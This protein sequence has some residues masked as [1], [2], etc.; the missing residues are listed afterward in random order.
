MVHAVETRDRAEGHMGTSTPSMNV[1]LI[2]PNINV[3]KDNYYS[4]G[5]ASI[6]AVLKQH[7][8]GIQAYN[9]F[10]FGEEEKARLFRFV[11][12][13]RPK[14]IGLTCVTS[15]YRFVKDI[16]E[17]LKS[18]FPDIVLAVGGVHPTLFP[19]LLYDSRSIDY[20]F[21]GEA[22]DTFLDFCRR[23]HDNQD[24]TDISGVAYI[25][26]DN[27]LVINEIGALC[28]DLNKFPEPERELFDYG[29]V[30]KATGGAAT[31]LF[32][33]GCPNACTFCSNQALAEV[34]RLNRMTSRVRDVDL[35]IKEIM[36]VTK[37]YDVQLIRIIDEIMGV[38]RQ[39]LLDF[40][41]EYKKHVRIPFHCFQRVNIINEESI[42]ALKE[43]GCIQVNFGIESG[44]T[45]IRNYLMRKNISDEQ[46]IKAFGT[47]YKLKMNTAASNIIGLPFETIPM[48]YDTINL[49]RK[50]LPTVNAVN[51]FYPYPQTKLYNLCKAF[52]LIDERKALSKDYVERKKAS[53]LK[54]PV[55]DEM[56]DWFV[57]N[58]NRLIYKDLFTVIRNPR[59]RFVDKVNGERRDYEGKPRKKVEE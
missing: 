56:L 33:R 58:W 48:I 54:L 30:L 57:N 31:F 17:Y 18:Q 3:A 23:V 22:E 49:N 32:N 10:A 26:G 50:I 59:K 19:D 44:N 11:S 1:L 6:A 42:I 5:L 34:Y 25:G 35:A 38:K 41:K 47:C 29:S 43:A 55:K 15:Q 2:Y 24:V 14:V 27:K 8:F 53:I 45:M 52:D 51:I 46:I 28:G 37:K 7:G 40:C 39:W 13:F 12:D 36:N 21:R 16:S 9:V 4:H 20:L